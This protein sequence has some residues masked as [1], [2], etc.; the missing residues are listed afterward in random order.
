MSIVSRTALALSTLVLLSACDEKSKSD[1]ATKAVPTTQVTGIDAA[2]PSALAAEA[3]PSVDK[4][5]ITSAAQ[6]SMFEV[7]LGK[8]VA[9]NATSSEVKAFAERMVKD[10]G[11][12]QS[13]LAGVASKKGMTVPTSLEGA[14]QSTV[15]DYA[16]LTGQKL[17]TKYA[18]DMVEDHENDVKAF[19]KAL[20]ELKDPDLTAW[21]TKT[22]PTLE[23]HLQMAKDMSAKRKDAGR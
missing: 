14:K 18:D 4:E 9:K 20:I 13:E 17:D 7:E 2:T 19:K 12:A 6:G 1:D 3:L 10:H 16:K 11:A 8:I 23:H 15:E 5:F 22:L 21:A